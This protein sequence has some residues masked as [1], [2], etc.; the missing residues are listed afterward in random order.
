MVVP[1][2]TTI[3][4]SSS[5]QPLSVYFF[6]VFDV[7]AVL[8]GLLEDDGGVLGKGIECGVIV[9][10]KWRNYDAHADLK[11]GTS[12]PLRLQAVGQLPE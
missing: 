9:E 11:A 1:R 3:R 10:W 4:T 5:D 6:Y 2:P 7:H 8:G 12:T